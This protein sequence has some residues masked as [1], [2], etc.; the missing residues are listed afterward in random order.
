MTFAYLAPRPGAPLEKVSRPAPE[1]RPEEIIVEVEA[2]AFGV[3]ELRALARATGRAPG[4][5]AVGRVVRAGD[6]ARHLLHKRVVAGPTLACGDC[7]LCRRGRVATCPHARRYGVDVD[8]AFASHL[9]APARWVLALDGPFDGLFP[10]PAAAALA[11]EAPLAYE[12][13]AR[14]GVAPGETT[15]W[16]GDS[17][18]ASLGAAVARAAGAV[19]LTLSPEEE[20][21][22]PQALRAAIAARAGAPPWRAFDTSGGSLGRRRALALAAPGGTLVALAPGDLAPIGVDDA[23]AAEVTIVGVAGPHPDLYPEVA[24]LAARG[25][26][27]LAATVTVVPPEEIPTLPERLRAGGERRLLVARLG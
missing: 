9:V 27:D 20:E 23:L 19:G 25:D 24:A 17:P 4:A 6:A 13:L 3:P 2:A 15:I 18:T 12:M 26:I 8:G 11:R 14:A 22:S 21:L 16:L 1:P 5:A 7:D 10:G